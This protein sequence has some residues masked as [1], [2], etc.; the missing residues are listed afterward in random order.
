MSGASLLKSSALVAFVT[1]LGIH[2]FP[3]VAQQPVCPLEMPKDAI[4]PHR[5][6]QGWMVRT[7]SPVRLDSAGMLHGAYDGEGYLKPHPAQQ[8]KRGDEVVSTQVWDFTSLPHYERWL[9]CGYGPVELYKRIEQKVARCTMKTARR[10]GA[11]RSMELKC[12][13]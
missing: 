3:A 9:V 4:Q 1:V 13:S 10:D 8:R 5:L 11:I 6:P 2:A 7:L 12:E